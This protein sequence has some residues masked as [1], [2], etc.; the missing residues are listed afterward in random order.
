MTMA[1]FTIGRPLVRGLRVIAPD[2]SLAIGV[3]S[4]ALGF[5]MAGLVL[6]GLA[7]AGL[8]YVPLI[9]VLTLGAAFYGF[10]TM[11][12]G[13]GK[14]AVA[15]RG[16][17]VPA[18]R[19]DA[20][21]MP[22]PQLQ[23]GQSVGRHCSSPPRWV[24]RGVLLLAAAACAASLFSALAPPIAGDALCY[25]L[26]LPKT[27][28]AEHRINFLPFD[29]N[30]T[31]PMLTEMWYLWGLALDGGVAAQLIHWEMGILLSLAAVLLAAPILGRPWAWIVGALVVL[32]P[33]INNQMT[34]PLND[35][36]LA[37][38]TT[39]AL[40]AWWQPVIDDENRRWFILAG[41][42]A[43]GALG[44][45]YVALT[46]AA[47]VGAIWFWIWWRQKA[48][49]QFLLQGA[50][51]VC[52]VA[53]SVGGLWYLRAAWYRGNPVFPF[54]AKTFDRLRGDCAAPVNG[55]PGKSGIHNPESVE[56]PLAN[57]APL[58]RDPLHLLLSPW[59]ITL[60]PEQFGGRA[61]QL[62]LLWL[63]AVPGIFWTRRLRGLFTLLALAGGYWVLWYLMRQNQ[64][65]LY[66]IVPLLSVAAVWV[67]SELGLLP[68]RPRSV[69]IAAFAGM[70]A[71]VAAAPLVR[72]SAHLRVALGL[73]SRASYLAEHEPTYRA[74]E[75]ANQLLPADARILSQ[76][77]RGFYFHQQVVREN[78]YRRYSRYDRQIQQPGDLSR[79]LRQAGFTHVLLA[80]SLAGTGVQ[81]DATLARL[82]DGQT[83]A[84]AESLLTLADYRFRDSDGSER[85]YRLLML[86]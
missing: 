43:G 61:H 8:L 50:A 47:V 65:F 5:I 28:L 3:W 69:A 62:G 67:W 25:H 22:A 58:G 38:L 53:V 60:H 37:T 48:R 10:G 21:A 73:Q 85:R 55:P 57:K 66:P 72:C 54:L 46:F 64:R 6:A 86:R 39:L 75:I 27:F 9:G 76:D 4:I 31:F 45:K 70:L 7:V 74:A 84:D 81:Y 15:S 36:A 40:V 82:T 23:F 29:D 30:S 56:P 35:V 11:L 2:D 83:S 17:G 33:G 1:A 51:V 42:A 13:E 20:G 49:R 16:T 34:A 41:L 24:R 77:Y 63:A 44:T 19:D 80:E 78:V 52:V 12:F 79:S 14:F 59:L 32:T 68:W 18:A 26:E 71:M